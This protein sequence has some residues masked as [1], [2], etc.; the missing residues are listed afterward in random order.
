L[1]QTVKG[2]YS[3]EW[4]LPNPSTRLEELTER[5]Y[6]KDHKKRNIAKLL[7]SLGDEVKFGVSV[8]SLV[9]YYLFVTSYKLRGGW[10]GLSAYTCIFLL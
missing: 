4:R 5:V 3:D 9:R 2:D 10:R 1:I 7:F 8:Y 6:R